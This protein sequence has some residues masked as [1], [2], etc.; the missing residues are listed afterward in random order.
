M[1]KNSGVSFLRPLA[2]NQPED[3]NFALL[4]WPEQ[5]S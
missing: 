2:E 4:N 5:M 1:A 3:K